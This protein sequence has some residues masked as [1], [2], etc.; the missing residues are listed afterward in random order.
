MKP[1]AVFPVILLI[2]LSLGIKGQSVEELKKQSEKDM[3]HMRRQQEQFM[4]QMQQGFDAFVAQ[5]DKDFA[6]FLKQ[7]WQDFEAFRSKKAPLQPKPVAIPAFKPE[8]QPEKRPGRQII[9]VSPA[10]QT[11][12]VAPP[13]ATP[14]ALIPKNKVQ[15]KARVRFDFYGK[16]VSVPVE[17]K[18]REL[19]PRRYDHRT[20]SKWWMQ[21]SRTGYGPMV[22]ALLQTSRDLKLNDWGYFLLVKEA[23]KTLASG[24]AQHALLLTWFVMIHSG[25]DFRI[26][27][28][29]GSLHLLFPTVQDVYERKY[30]K[31]EGRTYY[32]ENSASGHTFQTYDYIFPK[33][34]RAVDFRL[35]QEPQLGT[36]LFRKTV[37]FDYT[38]REYRFSVAT[39]GQIIRFLQH[40][41]M[42]VLPVYFRAPLTRTAQQ[43]LTTV[44][45]PAMREMSLPEKLNFLL[46]FV[47][48]AFAYE[49]DEQ[50]FGREKFF[51]PDE[52][53]YYKA[54]DCEDRAVFF[55]WL[56]R[57][58]LYLKVIGL[59][60]PDHV[61][62]A[63]ALPGEND[64][65]YVL[66]HGERYVVA[67]PTYIGAPV[68]MSIPRYVHMKT[69]II[70]V[71]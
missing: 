52:I 16:T 19:F 3:Q 25:Y 69:K 26:A 32:F 57:H 68:G 39:D 22:S 55:S 14:V 1:Q 54:S 4:A 58:F 31:I 34:T 10:V 50:Q 12:E 41:P 7:S 71:F 43:S 62:T 40:Y 64:A 56:V 20:I 37:A 48:T 47:Q 70:P 8:K 66:F 29:N 51:F 30:L 9:P 44:L 46:H 59:V 49:T 11:R 42:T 13:A 23:A 17:S 18:M 24:D 27:S 53:L 45:T 2:L 21:Y 65:D 61:T 36:E 60:Y 6:G 67:D 33:A 38:G 63:V 35:T 28:G 15:E 5:A